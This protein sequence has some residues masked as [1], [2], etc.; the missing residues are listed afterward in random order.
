MQVPV[1]DS[2]GTLELIKAVGPFVAALAAVIGVVLTAL[3]AQRN[4][5]RQRI[6][7]RADA[8]QQAAQDAVSEAYSQLDTYI[9]EFT[10]LVDE[11]LISETGA[12]QGLREIKSLSRVEMLVD[13]YLPDLDASLAQLNDSFKDARNTY[14]VILATIRSVRRQIE[15][16]DEAKLRMAREWFPDDQTRSV[17]FSAL[18]DERQKTRDNLVRTLS[19]FPEIVRDLPGEIEFNPWTVDIITRYLKRAGLALVKQQE[20]EVG[21]FKMEL[22]ARSRNFLRQHLGSARVA[23]VHPLDGDGSKALANKA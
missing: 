1:E 6:L 7:Q 5:T 19:A 3:L 14:H 20:K 4:W 12:A 13:L 15:P 17:Y 18:A 10:A 22:R 8:L 9:S 11:E 16:E 23:G 21:R 2:G